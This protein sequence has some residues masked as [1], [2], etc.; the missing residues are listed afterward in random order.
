MLARTISALCGRHSAQFPR[1]MTDGVVTLR[2]ARYTDLPALY[3]LVQTDVLRHTNG[4]SSREMPSFWAFCSWVL[5]TFPLAYVIDVGEHGRHRVIGFVGLS[6]LT[7]GQ[8][9]WVSMAIL[10]PADRGQGYGHRALALLLA[11]L[12][13]YKAVGAVYADVLKT[14]L[15]SRRLCA[16]L[17][18]VPV[19]EET[20]R[21]RLVK[22]LT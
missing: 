4:V 8:H 1:R 12:A 7:L 14:N 20:T 5:T 13:Q 18:F 17:G 21:L 2:C 11:G 3:P 16:R 10:Q 6:K 15:P 9:L 22:T 19:G